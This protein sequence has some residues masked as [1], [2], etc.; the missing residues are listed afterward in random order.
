VIRGPTAGTIRAIV[1]AGDIVMIIEP[2]NPADRATQQFSWLMEAAFQSTA[3]V[4]IVPREVRRTSG[5]IV[6]ISTGPEDPSID[7]AG[8][9]ALAAKEKLIVAAVPGP[10]HGHVRIDKLTEHAGLSVKYISIGNRPMSDSTLMALF[11]CP[12]DERLIV[13]TRGVVPNDIAVSLA[14]ARQIPVLIVEPF[15]HGA[16]N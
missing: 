5:S 10:G 7:I 3:A 12:L 8:A 6:A 13:L 4:V 16:S 9:I 15:A 11:L 1:Q 2:A 14:S